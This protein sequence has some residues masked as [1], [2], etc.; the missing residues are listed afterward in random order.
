MKIATVINFSTN[1]T[2]F[3]KHCVREASVFSRQILISVC[4]HFFDGKPENRDL[5]QG[6]YAQFPDCK[7]I[8]YP[9]HQGFY[10]QH[11][12][13]FWH[14]LGRLLGFYYVDK[15]I[16]YV[17]FLDVDE[18]VDGVKFLAWLEDFP[19]NNY[20]ALQL[21][22]FWYFR[23]EHYQSKVWEETPLFMKKTSISHE[24]L[25]HPFE[26]GGA[27]FEV[28]GKKAGFIKGKDGLPM[29]HHYSWVRSKK[30]MLRKVVSWGH[31]GE[32]D[33]VTLVEEEFSHPFN[34]KD[35]IHGYDFIKVDPFIKLDKKIPKSEVK[36]EWRNVKLL[37]PPDVNKID[38]ILKFNC[39]ELSES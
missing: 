19:L 6:I 26:R 17:L 10:S 31:R 32:R 1:E 16:E 21:A 18:I 5:L 33:W 22:C 15:E 9:F 34:G 23:K 30:E 12:T 27:F 38:L 28:T 35:F 2:V 14:N 39:I 8:E 4:D 7:F 3:L 37:T 13:R 20:E 25:M 11:S 24:L 36:K 29:V